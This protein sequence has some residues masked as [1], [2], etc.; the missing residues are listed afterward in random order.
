MGSVNFVPPE[1]ALSRVTSASAQVRPNRT[2]PV[3][4][5]AQ[6]R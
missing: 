4:G 6:K 1:S 5:I 2:L 3:S